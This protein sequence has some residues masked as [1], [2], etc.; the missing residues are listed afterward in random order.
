[1]RNFSVIEC[2]QGTPEWLAA[3]CGRL[4]G[5]RAGDMMSLLKSGGESAARRDLRVQIVCERLTG[6]PQDDQFVN[7]DMRRGTE[8]EPEARAAYESTTGH[9]VIQTGFL[10][11]D[12]MLCGASLDG[13]IGDFDGIV[14]LKVP[15]PATHLKYLRGG[16]L[17][18]E[19]K[20][21]IVHNLYVSGAAFCDF[22]SYAPAFPPALRLFRVRVERS[23]AEMASYELSARAF[24]SQVD[25][26]VEALAMTALEVA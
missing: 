12:G 17:P 25:A 10:A 15:R 20:Y 8:L 6:L 2:E 1:M 21:Q 7:A 4:T 9:M 11:L 13:H 24:L 16:V 23:E 26:E 18:D 22:V 19:H 14:E 5:S 3:R